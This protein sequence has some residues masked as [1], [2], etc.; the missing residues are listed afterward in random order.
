MDIGRNCFFCTLVVC[1]RLLAP[2]SF[3]DPL[4][5]FGVRGLRLLRIV[6]PTRICNVGL[7]CRLH[8]FMSSRIS[9]NCLSEAP[10]ELPQRIPQREGVVGSFRWGVALMPLLGTLCVTLGYNFSGLMPNWARHLGQ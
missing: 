4:S 8:V 5:R 9:L 6:I 2:G 7:F 1:A 10:L 3:P